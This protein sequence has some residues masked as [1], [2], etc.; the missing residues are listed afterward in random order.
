MSIKKIKKL[1]E[2]SF[3]NGKFDGKILTLVSSKLKKKDLKIYIKALRNIR[4]KRIVKV[5]IPNM[6][7]LTES[8][9]SS[10][11]KFFNNKELLFIEDKS[12]IAG[13]RII[14][15][16][17]VYELNLKDSLENM[18]RHVQKSYD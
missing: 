5:Y 6:G 1:A 4:E 2:H 16:D 13:I 8:F 17:I 3:S 18:I 10:L 14:D 15:Y 11:K 7:I 12:L 9:R